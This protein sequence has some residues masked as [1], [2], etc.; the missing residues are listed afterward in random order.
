M[1]VTLLDE[2]P[3]GEASLEN[4]LRGKSLTLD[5]VAQLI[6][7]FQF[8]FGEP[9]WLAI[10]DAHAADAAR[11]LPLQRPP[12]AEADVRGIAHERREVCAVIRGRFSY[13]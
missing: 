12:G 7:Q 2:V 10:H 9:P 3:H 5:R 6:Q 4:A 13:G 1:C 11:P 8:R